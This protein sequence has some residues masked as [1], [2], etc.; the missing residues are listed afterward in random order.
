MCWGGV[1]W[2]VVMCLKEKSQ[3]VLS[4]K[5]SLI[6]IRQNIWREPSVSVVLVTEWDIWSG[7]EKNYILTDL[8]A[9]L[10][11]ESTY[12]V[13]ACT[14]S[15]VQLFVTPRSV[16]RQAR[17]L[18]WVAISSSR[19]SSLPKDQTHTSCIPWTGSWILYHWAIGETR[20]LL[21]LF[22]DGVKKSLFVQ[23]Y[24]DHL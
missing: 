16:A 21:R 7:I 8:L 12:N 23:I 13:P 11:I 14:L 15:C 19:E 2:G 4:T 18:E 3:S 5:W 10:W 1:R 20:N 22:T 17:I 6:L 24:L 9:K